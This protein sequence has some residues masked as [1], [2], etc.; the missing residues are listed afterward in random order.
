MPH[1]EVTLP[2]AAAREENA[3]AAVGAP[4][5]PVLPGPPPG[6]ELASILILCSN[7]LDYTQQCLDSVLRHTR[8]CPTS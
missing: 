2:R 1:S 3:S 7:Q 8:A 5:P 4:Q 6:P